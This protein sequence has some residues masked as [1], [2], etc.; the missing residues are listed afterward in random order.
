[1]AH[2][3]CLVC[4]ISTV[5]RVRVKQC[6]RSP[7]FEH[8]FHVS[9]EFLL[10]CYQ[11]AGRVWYMLA[12]RYG[13]R[14]R[15]FTLPPVN[16]HIKKRKKKPWKPGASSGHIQTLSNLFLSFNIYGYSWEGGTFSFLFTSGLFTRPISEHDFRNKLVHFSVYKYTACV[17]NLQT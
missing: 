10:A 5:N 15:C 14:I 11:Q 17:V 6:I 9:V 8:L 4:F 1:M 7:F 16:S 2:A 13:E 12:E 3:A